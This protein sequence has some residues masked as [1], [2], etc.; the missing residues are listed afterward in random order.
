MLAE[1]FV[2]MM[3]RRFFRWLVWLNR[4]SMNRAMT[5]VDV[6]SGFGGLAL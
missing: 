4:G 2:N 1:I 3:M 5:T 6:V